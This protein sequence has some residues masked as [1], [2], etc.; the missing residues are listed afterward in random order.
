M[1]NTLFL[2]ILLL[3]FPVFFVPKSFKYYYS[4]I[5]LAGGIILSSVWLADAFSGTAR[6]VK[7]DIGLP[8]LQNGL[9][10]TIDRL[11]A[12]FLVV[13]NITV[14]TGFLYARDYIKP[15]YNTKNSLRISIHFFSCGF[16]FR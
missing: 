6:P 13:I 11:S 4:L 3:T 15:H 12:F 7:L 1:S 16:I 9:I 14:I 2:I 8:F 5:V 10:L